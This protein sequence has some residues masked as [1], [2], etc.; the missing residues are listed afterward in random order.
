MKT[1]NSRIDQLAALNHSIVLRHDE[2]GDVVASIAELDGCVAHGRDAAEAL[3]ELASMKRLWIESCLADGKPVPLPAE[4]DDAL[5]SGKWLQRVPRT[6]HRKLA[7]LAQREGVSLNQY[8]VSVLAEAVGAQ[9][10]PAAAPNVTSRR[11][12]LDQ[13]E[14]ASARIRA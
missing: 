8:V 2:E 10:A 3:A 7:D 1:K 5:P 13:P 9:A 6:L 4:E 12:Q 14:F 11:S